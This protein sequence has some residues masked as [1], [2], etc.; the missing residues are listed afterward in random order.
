MAFIPFNHQ[1]AVSDLKVNADFTIP[2]T[3]Y[4]RITYNGFVDSS[5]V[6]GQTEETGIIVGGDQWIPRLVW[7][8]TGTT[9]GVDIPIP[10][11][12]ELFLR[13][14][15]TGLITHSYGNNTVNS[16]AFSGAGALD[17][18][19][20]NAGDIIEINSSANDITAWLRPYHITFPAEIWVTSNTLIETDACTYN[21]ELYD[22]IDT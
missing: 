6:V 12:G 17:T 21:V 11:A 15:V 8:E 16:A 22:N 18:F 13:T 1:P 20:V 4:A 10:V 9:S 3:Q 5:A 2:A 7:R 14:N 19:E